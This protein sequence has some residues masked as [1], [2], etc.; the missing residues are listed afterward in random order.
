MS[1][2]V[3]KNN[4][5]NGYR[6]RAKDFSNPKNLTKEEQESLDAF[7]EAMKALKEEERKYGKKTYL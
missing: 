2:K 3:E 1:K 4:N 6:P 7:R 5:Q